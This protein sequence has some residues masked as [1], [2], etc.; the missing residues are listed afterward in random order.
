MCKYALHFF[1]ISPLLVIRSWSNLYQCE[2]NISTDAATC[3]SKS[4]NQC[5]RRQNQLLG[6]MRL[7][8]LYEHLDLAPY[9]SYFFAV[10]YPIMIKFIPTWRKNQR[11]RSYGQA[12]IP[13]LVCLFVR[14]WFSIN[15][16]I[17]CKKK[18][19]Q[20]GLNHAFSALHWTNNAPRNL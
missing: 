14:Q 10:C 20:N 15:E 9:F 5:V 2:G 12:E 8:N 1:C 13:E 7:P 4:Q 18:T 19:W 17:N 3:K 11:G 16:H 6:P